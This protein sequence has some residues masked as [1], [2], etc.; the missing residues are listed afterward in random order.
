M[1]TKIKTMAAI[2][3]ATSII[4]FNS[5]DD[6]DDSGAKPE[7]QLNEVGLENSKIGVIG[8]DLHVEAQIVAE[9]LINTV[10]VEIHP[11]GSGTWEFDS[12]YT[13]FSDLK[14]TEFHKHIDIPLTAD[15][16]DYHLHF[17]VVDKLGNESTEESELKIQE[18]TDL[19]PPVITITAG[20]TENQAFSNGQT[21][22]I[23]GSVSDDVALGGIFIGLVPADQE[24]SDEEVDDEDGYSI[25]LL[26]NHEFTNPTSYDFSASIVVGAEKDNNME[27]GS[28]TWTPGEYYILV[29]SKDAFGGNWTFSQHYP[30]TIN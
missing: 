17:I 27:P 22:S 5:C 14:N 26:H 25:T 28:I 6:D 11:E 7:I 3:A 12:I 20:P 23:S 29:K 18:P 1:N 21:I 13:E 24:L 9:G 16:G 4:F 8:S 19:V 10:K 30:L 2:L 15:A